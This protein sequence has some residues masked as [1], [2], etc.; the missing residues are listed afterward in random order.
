MGKKASIYKILCFSLLAFILP[1]IVYNEEESIPQKITFQGRLS[2]NE[3]LP[4]TA[5]FTITFSIY[6]AAVGGTKLWEETHEI[7]EVKKGV[8][9]VKLGKIN[10]LPIELFVHSKKLYLEVELQ[11]SVLIPRQEFLSVPYTFY[12]A[13][14][15]TATYLIGGYFNVMYDSTING[16]LGIGVK[17]PKA[18]LHVS[19]KNAEIRVDYDTSYS[20]KYYGSL[21]YSGLQ[22]GNPGENRIIAGRNY[23]G[24]SLAFYVNNT[25]DAADHNVPSDGLMAMYIR[26]DGYIGIG[27]T[28]PATKFTLRDGTMTVVG[29][30]SDLILHGSMYIGTTNSSFPGATTAGLVVNN[31]K[32]KIGDY[33]L[34][35]ARGPAGYVLKTDGKGNVSWQPDE[36][37][38][39]GLPYGIRGE[40]LV[41]ESGKNWISTNTIFINLSG[42]NVGIGT[43][44]PD[45]SAK[46]HIAG[47]MRITDANQLTAIQF[48]PQN[49][50]HRVAFSQLRFYD[51]GS[52]Q[53]ILTL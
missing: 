20:D 11:D 42:G 34:P 22:L 3:G 48:E 37:G 17:N 33:I 51:W 31:G 19:G 50:F 4:I 53:D 47:V 39:S 9:N 24:G 45:I 41:C 27:T 8:F 15:S 26:K 2:T 38:D 40:T 29:A 52:G 14:A 1:T 32:V 7:V 23:K 13:K 30:D 5:N 6:D 46:L 36:L 44:N 43:I 18:K 25:T 49:N 28:K 35:S 12:S 10:P 21:R 16:N